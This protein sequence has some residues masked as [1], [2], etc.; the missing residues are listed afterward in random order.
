MAF[1]VGVVDA[2][3]IVG[4]GVGAVATAVAELD[5]NWLESKTVFSRPYIATKISM[6]EKPVINFRISLEMIRPEQ[7]LQDNGCLKDL[8]S[9][10]A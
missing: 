7:S 8:C 5:F 1:G 9:Q 3:T 6:I 4:L 10:P 2:T